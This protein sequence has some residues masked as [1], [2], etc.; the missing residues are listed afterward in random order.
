[1]TPAIELLDLTVRLGQR[2]VLDRLCGN[3]RGRAI[4][5]LGPNGAGKSTLLNTLLGFYAPS[6][7]SARIFG[8]DPRLR[9]NEVRPWIGYMPES[10]AFVAHMT[11]VHFVRYMAE[12]SGL[13]AREA[14]ER[15]HEVLFYVGLG[16]ERYRK[17]GTYSIGMKQQ[18]KL[19]QAIVHGP[20]LLFLDEP[21]NGLDPSA[22]QRMLRLIRQI[23]DGGQTRLVISS[24]LLP[25]VEECCD[26]VVLLKQGRIHA[27]VDLE[28]QRRANKRLLDVN[29]LG[30]TADFTRGLLE[31]GCDCAAFEDNEGITRLRVVL[32]EDAD[33]RMVYELAQRLQVSIRRLS[34]RRD[35]LEELFLDAFRDEGR[36]PETIELTRS[37]LE[38]T[39]DPDTRHGVNR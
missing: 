28:E 5:L 36:R 17:L 16:E 20:R 38:G 25:D 4:G 14:L 39:M 29:A 6:T 15:T 13:P 21:T 8:V 31:L 3:F 2:T 19:A 23:R 30:V 32:G 1:M 24:H 35:S 37:E 22:R 9:P 27:H 12:L 26:E 7:G 11:G 10:D 33:V 18:I 34:S